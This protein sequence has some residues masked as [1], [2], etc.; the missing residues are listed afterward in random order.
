MRPMLW[1]VGELAKQ[2]GMTVRALHHYDEI[3]LLTPSHHTEAGHRLYAADDV[4]RLQQIKS[5]RDLGFSLEEIRD[6]LDRS[7]FSPQRVIQLHIASLRE[8][9]ELQRRLCERLEEIAARLRSEE[10][11]SAEEFI[12]TVMEVIDMSERLEKYYTP[13][14]RE[15]IKERARVLGEERIRQ[16]EAEWGE[17]IEQVRAEMEKGTDP[18]SEPVRCLAQRWMGLV[19][20]FTGG[21]PEIE[22]SLRTMWQQE[23]TIHG[24]DT[25][26]MREMGEYVSKAIAA[27][28]KPE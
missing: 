25:G 7:G 12:R 18:A 14:Q 17:L 20:E 6:C 11:S 9:I 21:D 24:I 22:R 23:E 5:L 2:T 8:R 27:S 13:E 28:S 16:A 26:P 1:K 15:E 19:N 4:A 10:E 3:G